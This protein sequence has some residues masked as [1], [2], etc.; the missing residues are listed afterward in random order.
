MLG[1]RKVPGPG[2]AAALIAA[3]AQEVAELEAQAAALVAGAIASAEAE[4]AEGGGWIAR[5]GLRTGDGAEG[6]EGGGGRKEVEGEGEEEEE[7]EEDDDDNLPEA[8]EEPAGSVVARW[9]SWLELARCHPRAPARRCVIG[10]DYSVTILHGKMYTERA[11][12]QL[13]PRAGRDRLR[14]PR[15]PAGGRAGAG[16]RFNNLIL[17][18]VTE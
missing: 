11:L 8:E 1:W 16:G 15:L 4:G 13:L 12:P 6:V 18:M 14:R 9:L 17:P 7:E 10:D 3:A 2:S 5:P